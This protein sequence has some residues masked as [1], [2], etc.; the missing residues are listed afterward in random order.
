MEYQWID[1]ETNNV[2]LQGSFKQKQ[3]F[4]KDIY[5]MY[6]QI[7][8]KAMY[9]NLSLPYNESTVTNLDGLKANVYLQFPKSNAQMCLY[10]DHSGINQMNIKHQIFSNFEFRP[11]IAML[12]SKL[13]FVYQPPKEYCV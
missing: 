10:D 5:P 11:L 6:Q 2:I 7:G 1:N 13:Q 8:L 3:S 4:V 12:Y 9:N